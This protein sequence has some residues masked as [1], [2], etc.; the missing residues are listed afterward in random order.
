MDQ[1]SSIINRR[2]FII[3]AG[4]AA[5]IGAIGL[6]V[7]PSANAAITYDRQ[8]AVTWARGRVYDDPDPIK[9][10]SNCTWYASKVLWVGGLPIDDEWTY[11]SAD[12]S[13]VASKW[14]YPGPTRTA[15]TADKLVEYLV[16]KGYASHKKLEW[17]QNDVPEAQ[18]GDIIGYD[19]DGGASG[20]IDHVMVVT[21]F[22]GQYPLV[23]GHTL[24]RLD[25]GWTW[26]QSKSDWIERS[27]TSP[28]GKPPEAHLYHILG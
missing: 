1:K 18:L 8:R 20:S 13:K 19:W 3:G 17:Y 21:G 7:A 15:T 12:L 9:F 28:S 27:Y 25:A 26:S 16:D 2:Q 6:S 24:P 23:S 14:H 11:K 5:A 10:E 4:T 22:S